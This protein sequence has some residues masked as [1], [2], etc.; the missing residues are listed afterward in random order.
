M[1][2]RTCRSKAWYL[3]LRV[4]GARPRPETDGA[5]R[6]AAFPRGRLLVSRSRRQV[7]DHFGALD[8][9]KEPRCLLPGKLGAINVGCDMAYWPLVLGNLALQALFLSFDEQKQHYHPKDGFIRGSDLQATGRVT[10]LPH[11]SRWFRNVVLCLLQLHSCHSFRSAI[12]LC[13]GMLQQ[14]ATSD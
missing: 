2:H 11:D 3:P 4:P 14:V 12:L 5:Q 9:D 7:A 13:F 1:A 8:V 6:G 10:D